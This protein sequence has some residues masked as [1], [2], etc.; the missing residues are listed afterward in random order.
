MSVCFP[1]R[2]LWPAPS[3]RRIALRVTPDAQR[4]LRQGHPWLYDQ[5]IRRQSHQGKPGDLA[6][7]FDQKTRRFVAIGLYD[8]T[9]PIRVRILQRRRPSPI[10]RAWYQRCLEAAVRRRDALVASGVT[11]GYRLVHGEND[12]LPGLVI[13]RYERTLVVKLYTVAWVPHLR[14]VLEALAGVSPAQR[15]ILRL[16]RAIQRH[17][18]HLHGLTDGVTLLGQPL[19]GPVVFLEHG[20][21]FE[22]DPLHGQKTGFFLDQRDNR[23]MVERL[24]AGGEVLDAF[25]Y[26][27]G[28]S[29]YAAR[30]G[31]RGV[32]MLEASRPAVDAAQRNMALN[33]E[34]PAIAAARQTL[35]TEDA[36]EG[37][38]RLHKE[39][40]YFDVVV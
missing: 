1:G 23:A 10:D 4:R 17:P 3:E 35:V 29:V 40:R 33:R 14:Q 39:R 15:V 5:S 34:H 25:A 27:G 8:P 9:S 20:L 7:V 37:L 36:F 16:S 32:T 2:R 22:V 19:D 12:G 21:R 30:G 11:T 26:T 28:F 31:A 6:V 18:E 24:A 38:A 13:D